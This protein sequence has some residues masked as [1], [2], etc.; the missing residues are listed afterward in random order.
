MATKH[1]RQD[2]YRAAATAGY[3][4]RTNPDGSVDVFKGKPRIWLCVF[5]N[6]TG[7]DMTVGRLDVAKAIRGVEKQ[8]K[9]LGLRFREEA[10]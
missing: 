3:T 10:R 1:T 7:L 2:L 4:V 9:F 8:A 5:Q 6:G